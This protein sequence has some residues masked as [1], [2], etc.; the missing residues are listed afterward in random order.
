MS[1]AN[2]KASAEQKNPD[3]FEDV[4]I[5]YLDRLA[6]LIHTKKEI[7]SDD[8]LDGFN[9]ALECDAHKVKELVSAL[10]GISETAPCLDYGNEVDALDLRHNYLRI[11][12]ALNIAI[13][14]LS[15]FSDSALVSVYASN[16][17]TSRLS[18]LKGERV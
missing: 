15:K 16:A 4:S 17:I 11:H 18:I 10:C 8:D 9:T 6:H 7:F 2:S 1:R 12:E 3:Y 5:R 13:D 14:A